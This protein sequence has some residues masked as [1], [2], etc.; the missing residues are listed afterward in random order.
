MDVERFDHRQD[1]AQESDANQRRMG[2]I[3]TRGR[4]DLIWR[5]AEAGSASE[6]PPIH[7]IE[8]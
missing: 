7:L 4:L 5:A 6:L 8:V 2:P 3:V 1:R